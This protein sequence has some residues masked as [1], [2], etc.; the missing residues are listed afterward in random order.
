MKKKDLLEE[1]KKLKI[2]IQHLKYPP[3][4]KLTNIVQFK[5]QK[6]DYEIYIGIIKNF[7][8]HAREDYWRYI[9]VSL[10]SGNEYDVK[11]NCITE[12]NSDKI[13]NA[14]LGAKNTTII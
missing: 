8:Y 12:I 6:N 2:E 13:K 4:F 14:I 3:K 1:I 5:N 10:E 7:Y 9:I 11:E